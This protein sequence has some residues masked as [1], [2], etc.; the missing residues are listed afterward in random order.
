VYGLIG[1]V[2]LLNT[3]S[4]LADNSWGDNESTIGLT[5]DH[6]LGDLRTVFKEKYPDCRNHWHSNPRKMPDEVLRV[7]PRTIMVSATLDILHKLQ[8]LFSNH[9]QAQGVKVNR[10]KADG[11]HQMK[12]MNQVTEAGCAMR[13]YVKQKSIKFAKHAKCFTDEGSDVVPTLNRQNTMTELK[14]MAS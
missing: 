12:D 4:D 10:M 8:V 9:L 1:L 14:A 11:L 3:A 13:R 7:L 6:L 5:P 2:P